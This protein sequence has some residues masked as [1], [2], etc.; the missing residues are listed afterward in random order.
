MTCINEKVDVD[1]SIH[2][3][4]GK[5]DQQFDDNNSIQTKKSMR[6]DWHSSSEE[7]AHEGNELQKIPYLRLVYLTVILL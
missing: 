3:S 4:P 5:P 6:E 2:A 1:L 7:T